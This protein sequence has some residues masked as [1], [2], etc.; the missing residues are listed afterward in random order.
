MTKLL[1]PRRHLK[2]RRI[3]GAADDFTYAAWPCWVDKINSFK[4]VVDTDI[5][6]PFLLEA[7]IISTDDGATSDDGNDGDDN[8]LQVVAKN[9]SLE[10]EN[11][12]LRLRVETPPR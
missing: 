4:V 11:K 2:S 10:F 5:V 8:Y 9:R 7:T 1:A 6:K 3:A 12:A